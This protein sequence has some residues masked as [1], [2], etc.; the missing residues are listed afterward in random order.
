[1]SKKVLVCGFGKMGRAIA[2]GLHFFNHDVTVFEA[3]HSLYDEIENNYKLTMFWGPEDYDLVVSALPYDQNYMLAKECIEAGTA[4]VDLGGH[5][6]TS[7]AIN[8]LATNNSSIVFTDVGLAPGLV[9]ILAEKAYFQI[10]RIEKVQRV[11]MKCG[12]VPTVYNPIDPL[13]HV[14]TWS[15]KGLI[16]EYKDNCEILWPSGIQTVEGMGGLEDYV[17]PSQ[18]HS[19]YKEPMECFYTSGGA[20]HTLELMKEREVAFCDYKTIRYKHHSRNFQ[21]LYKRLGDDIIKLFGTGAD[22]IVID[23]SAE[24]KHLRSRYFYEIREN[25]YWTAMQRATAFPAVAI[26]NQILDNSY[27]QGY[28]VN[29]PFNVLNYSN[30]ALEQFFYDLKALGLEL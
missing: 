10:A 20:A 15:V 12:G 28:D 16:N 14:G 3:N 24:G 6:G 29:G 4:Y 27:I 17:L 8:D 18:E 22:K 30:V 7:K 13:N 5:V 26:C 9:N 1:M 23:V 21:F 25:M 11:S 19:L 2:Y